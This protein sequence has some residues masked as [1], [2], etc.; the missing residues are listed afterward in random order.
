M[1]AFA[2]HWC[3]MRGNKL[4]DDNWPDIAETWTRMSTESQKGFRVAAEYQRSILSGCRLRST[5]TIEPHIF[6]KPFNGE[7]PPTTGRSKKSKGAASSGGKKRGGSSGFSVFSKHARIG[8]YDDWRLDNPGKKSPKVTD[9]ST[10]VGSMWK[11]LPEEE[12]NEWKQKALIANAANATTEEIKIKEEAIET[13]HQQPTKKKEKK[14]KAPTPAPTPAP[15]Q[16]KQ[17]RSVAEESTDKKRK[18]SAP[19]TN[20]KQKMVKKIEAPMSESSSSS[21]DEL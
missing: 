5:V 20:K 3:E 17:Q 16:S 7:H 21:E 8:L 9:F 4:E 14:S 6:V 10:Q 2:Q 11:A 18:I 13:S 15:T 1:D 19:E 12:K